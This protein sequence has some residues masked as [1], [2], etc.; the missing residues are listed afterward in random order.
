MMSREDHGINHKL[1]RRVI[2]TPTKLYL[3]GP[4]LE[5]SNRILRT[6]QTEIESFLRVTFTDDDFQPV[7][8]NE[9]LFGDIYE[10]IQGFMQNSI[11]LGGNE[12]VFL[13]YS[14]SQL[15][16][17]ACWFFRD[18]KVTAANIRK[19]MGDFSNIRNPAKFGAR[20]AQC[21]SS[22]TVTGRL[23]NEN[24]VIIEDVERNGYCFSDGVGRVGAIVANNIMRQLR[25]YTRMQTQNPSAFQFR[26]AG[27]KGGMI[28]KFINSDASF[29]C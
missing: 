23:D 1:V 9:A 15:R 19:R 17:Q 14:N 11:N 6:Y 24:I 20:M 12:F 16:S 10:R 25:K 27:C 18:G 26:M 8:H 7:G 5:I 22:T 13:H 2:V 28:Y 4:Q 3:A 21:F 29:V